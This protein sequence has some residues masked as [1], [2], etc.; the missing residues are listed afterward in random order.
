M[1]RFQPP[2]TWF[3]TYVSIRSVCCV[4]M[5]CAG[6]SLLSGR[7]LC[8]PCLSR[9]GLQ[10][11][12]NPSGRNDLLCVK[13]LTCTFLL[14][15]FVLSAWEAG[16]AELGL[17]GMKSSYPAWHT[18]MEL[19]WKKKTVINFTL[20]VFNLSQHYQTEQSALVI[21]ILRRKVPLMLS[22]SITGK[23]RLQQKNTQIYLFC[24]RHAL[25]EFLVI[26]SGLMSTLKNSHYITF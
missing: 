13:A 6:L 8:S 19:N 7:V 26:L 23:R 24:L 1:Q 25:P 3:V 5:S 12:L 16:W 10:F 15:C 14:I 11:W 18:V 4:Q 2:W 22:S 9:S 17:E 20:S 21:H